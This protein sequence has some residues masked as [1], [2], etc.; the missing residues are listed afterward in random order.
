V[1]AIS[2]AGFAQCRM[3]MGD[4]SSDAPG[5]KLSGETGGSAEVADFM[6]IG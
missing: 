1:W 5:L 6:E 4:R 2:K 3:A